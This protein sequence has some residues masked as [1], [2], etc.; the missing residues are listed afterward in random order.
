MD[1]LNKVRIVNIDIEDE[2]LLKSKFITKEDSDYPQE[3]NH[4]FAEKSLVT[5][6]ALILSN[7]TNPI[8][9]INNFL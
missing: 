2:N 6:N 1:I 5:Q 3:E 9:L 4:I 7:E 8:V